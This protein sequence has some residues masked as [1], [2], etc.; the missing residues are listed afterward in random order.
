MKAPKLY[1]RLPGTRIISAGTR[2][3]LWLAPD[4]LLALERTVGSER[5]RR[6]YLRDIEAVI[7]RR[8]SRRAIL[9]IVFFA[10]ALL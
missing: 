5:Y 8:T 2:T 6:F 3:S 9:N 1:Q 4:H 10:F 7:V